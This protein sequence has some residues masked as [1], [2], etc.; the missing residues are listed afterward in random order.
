MAHNL[1][2]PYLVVMISTFGYNRKKISSK[3]IHGHEWTGQK[4]KHYCVESVNLYTTTF[5]TR[6][7]HGF[8]ECESL[9]VAPTLEHQ[10]LWRILHPSVCP[11]G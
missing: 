7:H 11:S 3:K 9:V 6:K 8:L 1:T 4:H 2:L 10:P 5:N